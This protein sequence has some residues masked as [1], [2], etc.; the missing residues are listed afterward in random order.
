VNSAPS[1]TI[2]GREVLEPCWSPL[3]RSHN[4]PRGSEAALF[5]AFPNHCPR[6]YPSWQRLFHQQTSRFDAAP[7]FSLTLSDSTF[8]FSLRHLFLPGSFLFFF[9][10]LG[11]LSSGSSGYGPGRGPRVPPATKL[12]APP[13]PSAE[14]ALLRTPCTCA[15]YLFSFCLS[16]NGRVVSFHSP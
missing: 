5:S 7:V 8:S 10:A 12:T 3:S 4:L 14:L 13:K 9:K 2:K 15:N 6:R 16:V 11:E 1:D